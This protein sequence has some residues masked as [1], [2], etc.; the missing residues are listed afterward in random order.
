MSHETSSHPVSLSRRHALGA[1]LFLLA[2][3]VLGL[4]GAPASA[5]SRGTSGRTGSGPGSGSSGPDGALVLPGTPGN[6]PPTMVCN[7]TPPRRDN[8]RPRLPRKPQVPRPR[9]RC[10]VVRPDGRLDQRCRIPD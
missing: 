4:G 9:E 10:G 1:G 6:C 8:G 2:G 3:A 5:Q 7:A